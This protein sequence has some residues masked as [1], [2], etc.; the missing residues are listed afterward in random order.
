[1]YII[2]IFTYVHICTY[3][4][5]YIYNVY[6]IITLSYIYIPAYFRGCFK[7]LWFLRIP[8]R[9]SHGCQKKQWHKLMIAIAKYS[10]IL[11]GNSDITIILAIFWLL[12]FWLL[13]IQFFCDNYEISMGIINSYYSYLIPV[14]V[15][16]MKFLLLLLTGHFYV[17]NGGMG[18]WF[19]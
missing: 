3:M 16:A 7:F 6:P 8:I 15:I 4:Y 17:G 11:M 5:V 10:I 9:W 2:Y 14:I 12:L 19:D 18:W 13:S 1:M